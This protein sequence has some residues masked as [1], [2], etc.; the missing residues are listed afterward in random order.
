MVVASR[1]SVSAL[2][3]AAKDISV[4]AS[5][6]ANQR[7][8]LP[9]DR[10]EISAAAR[11]AAANADGDHDS[12]YKP[13]KVTY[14]SVEGGG[15]RLVVD[16][17]SPSHQVVFNPSD[18]N[19]DEMGRVAIPNTDTINELVGVRQ[20]RTMFDANLALIRAE[21]QMAGTLLDSMG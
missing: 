15:V 11:S 6:I 9:V 17:K 4:R 16:Q 19:T 3:A 7:N 20:S 2:G 13:G 18:P 12:I 5:N 1:S 21:N 8:S 10:V 14:D